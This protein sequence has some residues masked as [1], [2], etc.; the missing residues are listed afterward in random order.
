[1]L[2]PA[3]RLN[4]SGSTKYVLRLLETRDVKELLGEEVYLLW[5]DDGLWYPADVKK[6]GTMSYTPV[7]ISKLNLLPL[8]HSR[9][10]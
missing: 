6:V 3:D 9:K 4:A 5:P 2:C 7:G 8:P 10:L 1:M